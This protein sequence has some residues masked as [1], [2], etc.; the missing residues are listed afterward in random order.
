MTENK[1]EEVGLAGFLR[2]KERRGFSFEVHCRPNTRKNPEIKTVTVAESVAVGAALGDPSFRQLDQTLKEESVR[3]ALGSSRKQVASDTTVSRVCDVMKT[4]D[5]RGRM[6][7][8][9]RSARRE[10]LLGVEINGRRRRVGILDGSFIGGQYMSVM[11]EAGEIPVP[12]SAVRYPKRGKELVA[13]GILLRHLAKHDGREC[14]DYALDDGLYANEPFFS[15][16]EE[17]GIQAIVKLKP[18]EAD[19]LLI[20]KDARGLFDAPKR[21]TGVEYAEGLD[22]ERGCRYRVWGVA[23]LEWSTGGRTLK[24]VRVQ[25]EWL[26][27]PYK[28][29]TLEF[30]VISQDQDLDALTL[31]RLAHLRWFIENNEFKALNEQAHT[32]HVF[33]R[34][35]AGALNITLLQMMGRT[36]LELYRHELR[37]LRERMKHLWDHGSFPLRLLRSKLWTSLG[38]ALPN[39]S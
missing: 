19:R 4:S 7:G 8:M 22:K 10:G 23:G 38:A 35:S 29:Q 14:F 11:V 15:A 36:W 24:V 3:R 34:Q 30:W 5:L 17:A 33:R 28:G 12:V 2:T 21:L 37:R 25:E 13:S 1:K 39:T 18:E 31:R 20:L 9:W 6:K 16:C 32:K 27:G 26:K